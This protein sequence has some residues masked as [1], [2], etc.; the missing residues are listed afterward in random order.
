MR[1]II[2]IVILLIAPI[3]YIYILKCELMDPTRTRS[4]G[5]FI[6]IK[7]KIYIHK[8]SI[9]EHVI[10][11]YKMNWLLLLF[12]FFEPKSARSGSPPLI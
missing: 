12:F 9:V 7:K 2:V 6:F 5:P 11:E 4:V 8:F 1:K 10:K 3:Y